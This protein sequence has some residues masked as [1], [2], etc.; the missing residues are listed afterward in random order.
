MGAISSIASEKVKEKKVGLEKSRTWNQVRMM[1]LTTLMMRMNQAKL[2][3][4]HRVQETQNR[5]PDSSHIIRKT[6]MKTKNRVKMHRR[7]SKIL[8]LSCQNTTQRNLNR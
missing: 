4:T 5:I 7:A 2:T 3:C 1:K 6:K 8:N